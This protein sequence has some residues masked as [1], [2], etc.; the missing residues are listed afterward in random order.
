MAFPTNLLLNPLML[1]EFKR[2]A[3]SPVAGCCLLLALA[4]TGC[5]FKW[6]G[7]AKKDDTEKKE[8]AIPVEVTTITNG[9][10]ESTLK[11]SWYL[12]AEEQ[13]Q[14]IART[15]NRVK[16]LL[17]E[18]GDQVVK[19]QVLA[20]LEDQEQLT[21]V[22]KARNQ[23]EKIRTDYDRIKKL[24]EQNLISE[25]EHADAKFEVRQLELT[26]DEADRQLEFTVIRAPIKGTIT[27][28]LISLG[29][30][31]SNNKELFQ[32]IDLDS[33]VAYVAVPDKN[34]AQLRA[35]QPVRITTTA[36]PGQEFEG[37]IK[38]I[39][40]V[41]EAKTGMVKVTIG[42]KKTPLLRPGMY[43]EAEIVL[44]TK[45]DALLISRR[46]LVYDGDQLFVYRMKPNRRVERLMLIPAMMDKFFIEPASG[47]ST[48][49]Q[50]VIAG[51]TGLKDDALV[52]LPGDPD[53]EKG[54][55]SKPATAETAPDSGKS[56]STEHSS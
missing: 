56:D 22:N 19:D 1:S 32:I 44:A 38:R 31:I 51:H 42:V 30:L 37:Y 11:S 6:G 50:I 55:P 18:E 15:S 29:D 47:F 49:D 23:L 13:V 41:V 28:R 43:I 16:E 4:V 34:L 21:A 53:P 54:A 39:A 24:F 3:F 52:R 20:R 7:R 14:V 36:R 40:P 27:Q 25:K 2:T 45:T 9:P 12:E 17:V 46:A 26:V 33:L 5:D 35:K 8:Q 48:G 10:I